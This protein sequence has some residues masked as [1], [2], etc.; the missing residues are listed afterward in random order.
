MSTLL[1]TL[2]F[3]CVVVVIAIALL[4]IGWLIT[5]KSRMQPGAC[6]RAPG[7]KSKKEGCGTE[8]SC[9]LCDRS[10]EPKNQS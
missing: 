1:M 8:S 2:L 9:D 6:G 4:A 7:K 10:E 5:G 3:A